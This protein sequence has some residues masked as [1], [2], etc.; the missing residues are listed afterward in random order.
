MPKNELEN[1]IIVKLGQNKK[2]QKNF[3]SAPFFE[4]FFSAAT[5]KKGFKNG[6]A[7][8]NFDPALQ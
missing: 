2:G 8:K 3:L 7:R 1:L 4:S 6:A 5:G